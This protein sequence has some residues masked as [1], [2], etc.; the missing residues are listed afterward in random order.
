MTEYNTQIV[1]NNSGNRT[2]HIQF[3]TDIEDYFYMVE[4]LI[5]RCIDGN[6]SAGTADNEKLIEA[7][8]LL[9]EN[10][11]KN[12]AKRNGLEKC[13]CDFYKNGCI[14]INNYHYADGMPMHWPIPNPRRFTDA[15]IALAKALKMFGAHEV[16]RDDDGYVRVY[17]AD[18]GYDYAPKSSFEYFIENSK[19]VSID[20]IIK[21]GEQ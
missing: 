14:F 10:C 16:C 6:A 3:N 4:N 1:P 17:Y 13:N 11:E 5:R 20:D 21:E 7:A 2:Y 8:K 15:D 12:N 19:T 9:K 18:G